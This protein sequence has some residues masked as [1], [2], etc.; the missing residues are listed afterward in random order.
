MPLIRG[1]HFF[2]DH[3]TQIPNDWLRDGNLSL[4]SRGLLG[5]L[6][7]H[8]VGWSVS[9]AS[10]VSQGLEGREAIRSAIKELEQHGY[11]ERIQ[12]HDEAG[13]FEYTYITKTPNGEGGYENQQGGAENPSTGNPSTANRPPKNTNLKNTKNKKGAPKGATRLPDDFEPNPDSWDVMVEH[14]PWVDVKLETHKFR[15]YWASA[16][17]NAMKKDWQAAWRNWVRRAAE[18]SKPAEMPQK[19]HQF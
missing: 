14:F 12:G 16:T 4:K 17:R 7:S 13:K 6:M 19:K 10:L 9:V 1:Q 2:D 3:F 8:K 15:D 11:L 18:Y 5:L